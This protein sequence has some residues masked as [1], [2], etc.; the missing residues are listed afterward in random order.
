MGVHIETPISRRKDS[1]FLRK[2]TLVFDPI[3]VTLEDAY[4]GTF[5]CTYD[6]SRTLSG[7]RK[8]FQNLEVSDSEIAAFAESENIAFDEAM[9][10]AASSYVEA[11]LQGWK[12]TAEAEAFAGL[13]KIATS[14]D[15]THATLSQ[16][17]IDLLMY[18]AEKGDIHVL[19]SDEIGSWVS[20]GSRH[21][22]DKLD[23]AVSASYVEAVDSLCFR[24]LAKH[25]GGVLFVL[26]GTGFKIGRALKGLFDT[27]SG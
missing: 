4:D 23:P 11:E 27:R 17:E 26:T 6:I 18:A 15:P 7:L 5:S 20:V 22:S 2:A 16:E 9:Q 1:A 24:R 19:S 25:D 10:R 8:G 12:R 21:F 3:T 14:D 13:V